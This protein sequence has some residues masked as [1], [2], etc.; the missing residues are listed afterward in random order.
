M[1][2][3]VSVPWPRT[4][5]GLILPTRPPGSPE[6]LLFLS[7]YFWWVKSNFVVVQSLHY[8]ITDRRINKVTSLSRF[9]ACLSETSPAQVSI[10][11]SADNQFSA[12][13]CASRMASSGWFYSSCHSHRKFWLLRH[14][15]K[16]RRGSKQS[17]R[18]VKLLPPRL[19][20]I[21]KPWS[22]CLSPSI[23]IT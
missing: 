14:R 18:K 19:Q 15:S 1:V 9:A 16:L 17:L 7:G 10:P 3:W 20:C 8:I 21:L 13:F 11:G 5:L 22:S 12:V 2:C 4:E 6:Y 23:C